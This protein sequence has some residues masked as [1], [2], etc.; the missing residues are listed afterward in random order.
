MFTRHRTKR[1][2]SI[3]QND[4]FHQFATSNDKKSHGI[5]VFSEALVSE[6]PKD[7]LA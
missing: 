4:P 7:A 6:I 5:C 2:T 3:T 1:L